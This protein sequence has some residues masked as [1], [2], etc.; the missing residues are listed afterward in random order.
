[1]F[2]REMGGSPGVWGSLTAIEWTKKCIEKFGGDADNITVI[3]QSAG[4]EIIAALLLAKED[5][6]K[7]PFDKFGLHLQIYRHGKILNAR[8]LCLTRFSMQLHGKMWNV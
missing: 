1:M 2:E 8:G 6:I 3:C 7:L 5:S 4:A